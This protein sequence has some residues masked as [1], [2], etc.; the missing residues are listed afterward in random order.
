[1]NIDQ[2]PLAP[3]PYEGMDCPTFT[4]SSSTL[5]D[6]T[7]MPKSATAEA[8]SLSGPHVARIPGGNGELHAD[9]L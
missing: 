4:L 7:P 6:G 9:L 3:S 1:M 5:T 2:R 8:G